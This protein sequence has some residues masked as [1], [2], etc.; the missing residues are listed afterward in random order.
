MPEEEL[1]QM[2]MERMQEARARIN[3]MSVCRTCMT[4]AE[5]WY[6][7]LPRANTRRWP[8]VSPSPFV[9]LGRPEDPR[10]LAI[11]WDRQNYE[12]IGFIFDVC[13]KSGHRVR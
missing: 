13:R 2:A 8:G 7:N 11:E 4:A 10:I 5:S 12:Q 9:E 6:R 1:V 3:A